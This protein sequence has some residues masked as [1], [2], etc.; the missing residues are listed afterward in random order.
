MLKRD[1]N[2]PVSLRYHLYDGGQGVEGSPSRH[3]QLGGLRHENQV[4][5]AAQYNPL[6]KLSANNPRLFH[7]EAF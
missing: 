6:Q 3:E 5:L 1:G 7:L 4:G 2:P